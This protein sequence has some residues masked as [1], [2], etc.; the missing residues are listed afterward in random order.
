MRLIITARH[1]PL[2]E[3]PIA[4]SAL[5]NQEQKL[6]AALVLYFLSLDKQWVL[7]MSLD[8]M[9]DPAWIMF[10]KSF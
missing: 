6:E 3:V 9:F 5:S 10:G 4:K 8:T 2:P 7:G 1:L